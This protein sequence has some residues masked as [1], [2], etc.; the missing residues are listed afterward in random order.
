MS[1]NDILEQVLGVG[2]AEII[3]IILDC[4]GWAPM[5]TQS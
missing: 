4:P 5:F 2:Q 3:M 1:T